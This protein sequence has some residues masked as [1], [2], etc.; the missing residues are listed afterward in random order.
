MRKRRPKNREIFPPGVRHLTEWRT[1][2]FSYQGEVFNYDVGYWLPGLLLSNTFLDNLPL[3][4]GYGSKSN[5][6]T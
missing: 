3:R 4:L 1:P 5:R 2:G 6:T